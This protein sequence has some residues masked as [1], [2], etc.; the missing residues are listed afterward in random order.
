MFIKIIC[1]VALLEFSLS[2]DAPTLPM[3]KDSKY[4]DDVCSYS[5]NNHTYV[6]HCKKG[7]FCDYDLSIDGLD[8]SSIGLFFE[9]TNIKICQ[10][11]PNI[12]SLYTFSEKNCENDF[13][14]E[15]GYKCIG[16]VCTPKC[17]EN[18]FLS[19]TGCI[20]ISYKGTDGICEETTI[21]KDQST[22]YKYSPAEPNKICGK[23]T[24]AD[25]PNDDKKGIFYVNKKEY[26][27]KGTVEDGEYVDK[28]EL[29]KSGFA[30][31]FFKDGK[32]EDPKDINAVGNNRM[33][34]RCVTPISISISNEGHYFINYK[35]N[36]NGEILRYNMYKLQQLTNGPTDKYTSIYN[37]YFYVDDDTDK[38]SFYS[39]YIKLKYE[40]YREYY[41]NITEEERKTCEYLDN[42]NKYTCENNKLIRLWYFYKHPDKY[43]A[44]NDRKKIRKVVDFLIQKEYPCYSLSQFLSIKFIY[45]LFLFLF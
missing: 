11:L 34:L 30:L 5:K 43:S 33:Y 8:S 32:T 16:K 3:K 22:I 45:L 26:V 28:K 9:E 20:D 25:D 10:D 39:K 38:F 7:K 19:S 13:E 42:S 18:E 2:D 6:K 15:S 17:S 27:Y 40:K 29:C 37:N 23:L 21:R 41:T 44:Y 1:I 35:I 4:G 12:T 14:C 31:Y 36:E 24:F